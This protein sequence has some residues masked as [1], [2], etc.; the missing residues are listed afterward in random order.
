MLDRANLHL[1]GALVA[2][3]DIREMFVADAGFFVEFGV[4]EVHLLTTAMGDGTGIDHFHDDV[5]ADGAEIQLSF[6]NDINFKGLVLCER[7]LG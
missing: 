6:H 1:E 4:E 3:A 5:A 7:F 2:E